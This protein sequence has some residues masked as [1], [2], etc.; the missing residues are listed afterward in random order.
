MGSADKLQRLSAFLDGELSSAD[1]AELLRGIAQ[2]VELQDALAELSALRGLWGADGVGANPMSGDDD[3]SS[4]VSAVM[5]AI[6]PT[7]MPADHAGVEALASLA[8]DGA[9]DEDGRIYL[10]GLLERPTLSDA[11]LSLLASAE[12]VHAGARVD[13]A[14]THLLAHLP[15]H[16]DAAVAVTERGWALSAAAQDGALSTD[17]EAELIALCARDADLLA[18]L[19]DS[20][21]LA[22][23]EALRAARDSPVSLAAASRAG[24][25]ALQAIEA[26]SMRGTQQQQQRPAQAASGFAQF[27]ASLRAVGVPLGFAGAAAVAFIVV[28]S[29]PA[30]NLSGVAKA[31]SQDAANVLLA[32][33]QRDLFEEAPAPSANVVLLADNRADIEALDAAGTTMVFSTA[34]SNITVIWVDVDEGDTPEQGT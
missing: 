23:A 8:A 20:R 33:L 11:A 6:D 28:Q 12:A 3:P 27:L 25:A 34:E 14:V 5:A 26:A 29:S 2:D 1:E 15:D 9:L 16:I 22:I 7:A 17:E 30:G 13:G 31:P 18:V 21:S 10:D 19:H 24:E 32:A 4:V